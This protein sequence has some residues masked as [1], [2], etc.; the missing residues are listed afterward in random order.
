MAGL[1]GGSRDDFVRA[2]LG[3]YEADLFRY[4]R[5][6]LGDPDA[7]VQTF[8]G[9]DPRILASGW[10]DLGRP[11]PTVG[12]PPTILLRTAYRQPT[13]LAEVSRTRATL[14]LTRSAVRS[15]TVPAPAS[16][17]GA[18]PTPSRPATVTSGATGCN[19]GPPVT[20]IA[21]TAGAYRRE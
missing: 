16:T 9:A 4:A 17:S 3:R 15:L 14:S 20:A 8:R 21:C 19:A 10:T 11:D 13:A 1:P 2:A 7:A 6:M 12:E 18:A 5:R